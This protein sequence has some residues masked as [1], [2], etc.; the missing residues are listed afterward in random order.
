MLTIFFNQKKINK[1]KSAQF[2]QLQNIFLTTKVRLEYQGYEEDT[3]CAP[4]GIEGGPRPVEERVKL[5]AAG[6]RV[7]GARARHICT[8]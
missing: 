1:N 8:H 7:Q 6:P 4:L 3:W 2:I 5:A